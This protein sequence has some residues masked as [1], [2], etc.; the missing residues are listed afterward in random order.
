MLTATPS[1]P[2]T[3]RTPQEDRELLTKIANSNKDE[4]LSHEEVAKL[5]ADYNRGQLK[6]ERLVSI[7]RKYDKDG[8][9]QI[10]QVEMADMHHELGLGE[11]T[12]RYAGYSA[13]AA[14]AFRYLAFTSDFGEALRPVV[15]ARLVT[16]SYAVALGYCVADVGYEAYKH[17]Q[18]NYLT[19]HQEPRPLAQVVVERAAFQAVA[20]LAVP[21]LLIHTT[22]DVSK[23]FFARI[24]R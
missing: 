6:D 7:F 10:C 5:I 3:P 21:A 17:V 19:E 13:V 11:T 16:G 14:R 15:N 2:S 8:N 24:N 18:R 23:K 20:S 4:V 9:G 12:A 22:V 1:A